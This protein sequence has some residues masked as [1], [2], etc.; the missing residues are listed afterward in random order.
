MSS[1]KKL[2][3]VIVGCGRTGAY[4]ANRMSREGHSLV[5]IDSNS[6]AFDNLSVAF[7]GFRVEGDATELAMLRQAK[8]D[9]AD[10]VVAAAADDNINLMVAQIA[11]K[12]FHVP[13][14]IARVFQPDRESIYQA[15][16]IDTLC[17]TT[18]FGDLVGDIYLEPPLVEIEE[19]EDKSRE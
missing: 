16:G 6:E 17:P 10:L 2:F 14:V 4:L 13:R 19:P 1:N 12:I 7:S 11:K 15:L 18:L 9:R 5:V 8:I 3:I